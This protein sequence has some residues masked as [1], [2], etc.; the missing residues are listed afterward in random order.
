VK[1]V[2][3]VAFVLL[4][5]LA[6][7]VA[8]CAPSQSAAPVEVTRV[9][10]QTVVVTQ[11]VEVTRQVVVTPTSVPATTTPTSGPT[12]PQDALHSP[13]IGGN[14]SPALP[15]GEPG[16]LSV[17]A[18]G[19]FGGSVVPVIVRN[20]TDA[21]VTRVEVSA[22]AHDSSGAMLGAGG[23]QGFNPYLVMPGEITMG[24]VYFEDAQ[25][26]DDVTFDYEVSASEYDPNNSIG[27]L[28]LDVTEASISGGNVV[29]I[30]TNNSD[31]AV[32]GPIGAV[33]Y[34]FDG[35]GNLL[36]YH[37]DYTDKDNADPGGTIPFQIGLRGDECPVFLV[38]ASGYDF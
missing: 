21:T 28:D 27:G 22:T 36:D 18:A 16:K 35:D 3:F 33:V 15:D 9:V 17:I 14:Q 23:D 38:A 26:P 12:Q 4:L 37:S 13:F 31:K 2:K 6:L 19:K 34:C 11:V 1:S 5:S 7:I 25:F 10:E 20:N 24:Y 30:F 32:S 8:A 29:G